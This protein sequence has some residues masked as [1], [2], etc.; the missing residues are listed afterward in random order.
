MHTDSVND[1]PDLAPCSHLYTVD[2]LKPQTVVDAAHRA[3][4][5][6]FT[7]FVPNVM[8]EQRINERVCTLLSR[9]VGGAAAGDAAVVEPEMSR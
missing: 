9:P 4:A 5:H 6:R 3:V 8:S 7:S 1:R 2:F